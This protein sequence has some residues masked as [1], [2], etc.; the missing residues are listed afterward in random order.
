[1]TLASRASPRSKHS[2]CHSLPLGRSRLAVKY[3]QYHDISTD[4]HLQGHCPEEPPSFFSTCRQHHETLVSVF[5][6]PSHSNSV[7]LDDLTWRLDTYRRT[8][9]K[10][11]DYSWSSKNE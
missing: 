5:S 3:L 8:S 4:H 7:A 10:H 1:M 2:L 9:A 6:W 11:V